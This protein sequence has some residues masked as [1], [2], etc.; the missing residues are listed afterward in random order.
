MFGYPGRY[1]VGCSSVRAM[2]AVFFA[3]VVLGAVVAADKSATTASRPATRPATRPA[4]IK[5]PGIKVD[6]KRKV[7]IL[8][9]AFALDEGIIELVA[10]QKGT[11]DYESLL[12]LDG[13]PHKLHAAL[14]LLGLEPGGYEKKTNIPRGGK[15]V[16]SIKYKINGKTVTASPEQFIYNTRDKRPMKARKWVFCGSRMVAQSRNGP[17]RYWGDLTGAMITTFLDPSTV[18]ENP[19]KYREDDT[20]FIVYKEKTP[21]SGT[22]IELVVTPV[23][24]KSKSD[25]SVSGKK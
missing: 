8:T 1:W 3:V 5:W 7:I 21:P 4:I 16:L 14:L 24:E 13:A 12:A 25:K 9:G 10:C 2:A 23:K 15:V 22:R 20:V 11:K 17:E 18:L 6:L 19:G